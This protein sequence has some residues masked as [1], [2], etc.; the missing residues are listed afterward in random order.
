MNCVASFVC[1]KRSRR[2]RYGRKQA[3]SCLWPLAFFS[4]SSS[5]QRTRPCSAAPRLPRTV[6]EACLLACLFPS[7]KRLAAVSQPSPLDMNLRF[8]SAPS[9]TVFSLAVSPCGP[10]RFYLPRAGLAPFSLAQTGWT[11]RSLFHSASS[12]PD[13]RQTSPLLGLMERLPSGICLLSRDTGSGGDRGF[14]F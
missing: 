12:R 7:R 6:C 5:R 14:S 3:R 10:L 11:T 8:P 2:E 13:A 4:V 1:E 9:R